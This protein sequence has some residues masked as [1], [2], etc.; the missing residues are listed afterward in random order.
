M[1]TTDAGAIAD[2]V[3]D[4]L[5]LGSR[6]LKNFLSLTAA[7]IAERFIEVFGS[8]YARRVL[9]VAAIGQVSWTGAALSYFGLLV[10]PV[11]R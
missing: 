11:F 3:G 7:N 8:I 4:E 1:A 10:I 2:N 5:A 6:I 9:V